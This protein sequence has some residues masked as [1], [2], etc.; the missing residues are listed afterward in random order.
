MAKSKQERLLEKQIKQQKT[1]ERNAATRE[2][3]AS[4]VNSA[5]IIEGVQILDTSAEEV[6]QCLLKCECT[7][8]RVHFTDDIFPT[9]LQLSISIEI[10]KLVQY[11]MVGAKILYDNGGFVTLM[12]KAFTYFEDKDKAIERHKERENRPVA[13]DF[14][15]KGNIIFGDVID[16]TLSVNNSI[17]YIEKYIEQEAGEDKE[18]LKEI[19]EDV[20]ELVENIKDSR[21]IPKQK[22]LYSKIGDHAS[23]HSWFYGKVVEMLGKTI[24]NCLGS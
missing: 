15:N 7:D 3:A 5:Q 4:I 17:E 22:K 6:L 14:V 20:M 23:K 18:E 10:E 8:N 24:L 11:G 21:S 2:R 9:Y 1:A 19:L 16:S 13:G 12:P